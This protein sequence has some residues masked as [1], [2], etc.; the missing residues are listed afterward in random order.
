MMHVAMNFNIVVGD[1]DMV[2]FCTDQ[3]PER[4]PNNS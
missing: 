3:R 2:C 1:E 4:H